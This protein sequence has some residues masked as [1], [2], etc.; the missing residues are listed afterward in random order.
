[1]KHG[2]TPLASGLLTG[3]PLVLVAAWLILGNLGCSAWDAIWR[4]YIEFDTE[5]FLMEPGKKGTVKATLYWADEDK[6][7]DAKAWTVES[8][9]EVLAAAS[10]SPSGDSD[11]TTV[12]IECS[13][14]ASLFGPNEVWNTAASR[15]SQLG[16]KA[17]FADPVW[18][19]VAGQEAV[20]GRRAYL[21]LFGG[22]ASM[23]AESSERSSAG[24]KFRV[25]V[26]TPFVGWKYSY[27]GY[28]KYEVGRKTPPETKTQAF[29]EKEVKPGVNSYQF[30]E[31]PNQEGDDRNIVVFRLKQTDPTGKLVRTDEKTFQSWD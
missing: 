22:M 9:P 24:R 19:S 13:S 3:V 5:V 8:R 29:G 28:C 26:I 6:T 16:V 18:K 7:L 25:F 12:S 1:M 27:D 20:I 2:K 10:C 17:S 11:V 14:D 21:P 30:V 15:N 31:W 23:Y 4:Y